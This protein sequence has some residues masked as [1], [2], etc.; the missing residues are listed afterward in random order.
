MCAGKAL[1]PAPVATPLMNLGHSGPCLR[2]SEKGKSQF[3]VAA[4]KKKGGG[5]ERG[6]TFCP[7][8]PKGLAK[9]PVVKPHQEGAQADLIFK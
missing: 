1:N 3:F 5:Q 6:S 8:C 4:K 9:A 2:P 7:G